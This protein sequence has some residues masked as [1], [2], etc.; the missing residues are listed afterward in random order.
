MNIEEIKHAE[1]LT[2]ALLKKL[3]ENY[4]G[5]DMINLST[6]LM[7]DAVGSKEPNRVNEF[8]KNL[9]VFINKEL[10]KILGE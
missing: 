3:N 9:E 8:S 4:N 1:L 7:I 5:N 2:L 6:M 10:D